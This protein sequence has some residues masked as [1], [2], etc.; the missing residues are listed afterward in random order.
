MN[1]RVNFGQLCEALLLTI[2]L[3]GGVATTACAEPRRGAEPPV[4]SVGQTPAPAVPRADD[5]LPCPLSVPC[6]ADVDVHGVKSISS[7]RQALVERRGPQLLPCP[8]SVPCVATGDESSA[9]AP[10]VNAKRPVSHQRRPL[11]LRITE[12]TE[13]TGAAPPRDNSNQGPPS[14]VISNIVPAEANKEPVSAPPISTASVATAK[15]LKNE[16]SA[17]EASDLALTNTDGLKDKAEQAVIAADRKLSAVD[18]RSLAPEA[19]RT[20][21]QANDLTVAARRALSEQDYLAA[22]SLS[23]KAAQLATTLNSKTRPRR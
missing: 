18:S 16:P 19:A 12:R 22:A 7:P 21:D 3:V 17:L 6:R 23:T 10:S 9:V 11:K 4:S 5:L 13:S 2:I 14:K 8:M 20:Y 15:T 1:G